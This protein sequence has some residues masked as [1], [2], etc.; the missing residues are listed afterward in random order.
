MCP[1][2]NLH[3]YDLNLTVLSCPIYMSASPQI[4]YLHYIIT[5]FDITHVKQGYLIYSVTQVSTIFFFEKPVLFQLSYI[6]V[7]KYI[8]E[9]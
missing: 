1:P 8:S 4:L 2:L 9:M 6:A 3:M 7:K 5:T